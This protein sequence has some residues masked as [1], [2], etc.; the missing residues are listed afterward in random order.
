MRHLA[1]PRELIDLKVDIAIDFV[2]QTL[3]EGLLNHREDLGN[4]SGR[5]RFGVDGQEVQDGHVAVEFG[6]LASREVEV[7]NTY[8]AGLAQDVVINVGHISN[9]ASFET[10][11]S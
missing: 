7:V 9:T 2:G 11:V 5:P 1:E 6:H 3:V 10:L 8:F 4:R